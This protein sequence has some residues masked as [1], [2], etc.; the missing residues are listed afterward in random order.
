LYERRCSPESQKILNNPLLCLFGP[1]A[2]GHA[3]KAQ[4]FFT[5]GAVDGL[6]GHALTESGNETGQI[7]CIRIFR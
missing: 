4:Q 6:Y 2:E 1:S 7:G 3:G 5:A